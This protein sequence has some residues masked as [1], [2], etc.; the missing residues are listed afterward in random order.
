M[1]SSLA[2][3]SIFAAMLA[4]LA[5]LEAEAI[6]CV[7]DRTYET[8][9][10]DGCTSIT[11]SLSIQHATLADLDG[12]TRLNRVGQDLSIVGNDYLSNVD[13]LSSVSFV[14]GDVIVNGNKALTNV[15]GFS[16]LAHIAGSLGVRSHLELE[17]INGLSALVSLGADL[18]LEANYALTNLD[19]LSGIT[20]VP[21]S[22]KILN[23]V[24]LA[25]LEGLSSLTSVS[26]NLIVKIAPSLTNLD[27]LSMVESVG[28][29]LRVSNT[30]TADLDGLSAVANIGS[31]LQVYSNPG[32]RDVSGLSAL[33]E[34]FGDFEIRMNDSLCQSR[35]ENLLRKLTIGGAEKVFENYGTCDAYDI[36]PDDDPTQ[37]DSDGDGLIDLCDPCTGGLSLYK[38][39]LKAANFAS[40]AGDDKLKFKGKLIFEESVSIAPQVRGFRFVVQDADS[41]I[42]IYLDIPAGLYGPLRRSG[43]IPTPNGRKFLYVTKDKFDG[44]LPKIILKWNPKKANEVVV[45]VNGK[46][47]DFAPPEVSLPL[48][49]TVSLDPTDAMTSLCAEAEFPGPKPLPYCRMSGNGVAVT[50]K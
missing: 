46:Q 4:L 17:N 23:H 15:D 6:E 48:K 19:G 26:G 2:L 37:P 36:C 45:I 33:T 1:R 32:L 44:V 38:P 3:A 42:L 30:N 21:G 9:V 49:A 40:P 27:G 50:C 7:G 5:P 8:A 18:V 14:G 22:L 10:A 28:S 39:I 31:H 24:A 47:G 34:V 12:L 41:D 11:G 43:W 29:L 16:A 20:Q 35:V 25:N 13:G